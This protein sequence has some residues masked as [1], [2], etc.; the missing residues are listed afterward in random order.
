MEFLMAHGLS[1]VFGGLIVVSVLLDVL[2]P[3]TPR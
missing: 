3:S 2:I 1:I